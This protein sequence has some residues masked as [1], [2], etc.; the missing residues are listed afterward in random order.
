[1]NSITNKAK[2]NYKN[3]NTFNLVNNYMMQP[4]FQ[5]HNYS[6][7]YINIKEDKKSHISNLKYRYLNFKNKMKKET[8]NYTKNFGVKEKNS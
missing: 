1:M 4:N 5:N 6:D 8:I 3:K 2:I 7:Y